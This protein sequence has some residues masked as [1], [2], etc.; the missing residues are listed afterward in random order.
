MAELRLSLRTV[1]RYIAEGRL[2]GIRLTRRT[3]RVTWASIRALTDPATADP[4]PPA[5]GAPGPQ[6]VPDSAG[7]ASTPDVS[8]ASPGGLA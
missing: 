5:A 3:T 1:D 8:P 4:Q 2:E 7:G 6:Q